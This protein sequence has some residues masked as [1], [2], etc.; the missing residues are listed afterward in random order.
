VLYSCLPRTTTAEQSS[1]GKDD[2]AAR[3][4]DVV[5]TTSQL[6]PTRIC[7]VKMQ[8]KRPGS[9]HA[10]QPACPYRADTVAEA[11]CAQGCLYLLFSRTHWSYM[12]FLLFQ[13]RRI[14]CQALKTE[15]GPGYSLSPKSRGHAF[16]IGIGM[17]CLFF[18]PLLRSASPATDGAAS[19]PWWPAHTWDTEQKSAKKE[20]NR[21]EQNRTEQ[22]RSCWTL[23]RQQT[24]DN[25]RAFLFY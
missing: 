10:G 6:P 14:T 16:F 21:T 7:A 4:Q 19:S 11:M 20:Q 15:T 13:P 1:L 9:S 8:L 17:S 23:E 3:V 24:H 22:S 25:T 5:L 2:S 18:V 12:A